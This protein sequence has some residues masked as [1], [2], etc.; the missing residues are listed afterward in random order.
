MSVAAKLSVSTHKAG[1]L[2]NAARVSYSKFDIYVHLDVGGVALTDN[3][4]QCTT[5]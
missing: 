5:L 3:G 2:V 1:E 4:E